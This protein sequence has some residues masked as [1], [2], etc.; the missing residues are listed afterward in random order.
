MTR[1]ES[2]DRVELR[3]IFRPPH[4]PLGQHLGSGK[5][6]KVFIIHNNINGID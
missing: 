2:D 1:T 4:L 5:I 3:K 6:L